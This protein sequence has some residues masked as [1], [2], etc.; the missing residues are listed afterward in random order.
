MASTPAVRLVALGQE[1]QAVA[2][3]CQDSGALNVTSTVAIG[4]VYLSTRTSTDKSGTVASG[5]S[6]QTAI[7]ANASRK[8]WMLSNLS[9]DILYVRDD[10]SAASA[11]TG[12]P[13]YP[14]QTINDG[15]QVSTS[16]I[17]VLGATTG[18]AY[19]AKEYT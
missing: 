10:G 4:D 12:V 1:G 8:G 19:S 2:L 14:G 3:T 9:N 17:S 16:L 11:T 7:A 6:A 5:G 18:D 13:L 15:G